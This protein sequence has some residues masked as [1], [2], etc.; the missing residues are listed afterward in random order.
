MKQKYKL[1]TGKY[2]SQRERFTWHL[3]LL[4]ILLIVVVLGSG[5]FL[6]DFYHKK[7]NPQTPTTKTTIKKITFEDK[8]FSTA[9]FSFKDSEAWNFID[10]QSTANKFVFQK[11]LPK[12]TLV[13]H[14]L[15]V[16][17]NTTPPP[18]DLAASR[19]LPI[20]INDDGKTFKVSQVSD[21]CGT[22]YKPGEIHRVS[23]RQISGATLLCDPDQGQFRVVFS[24]I[25][26]DYN[27]KLKRDNGTTANY[28]IIY[29]NQKI[30]PNSD[31]LMQVGDSF[32]AI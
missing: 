32:K 3:K 30:D 26:G 6:Y 23:T 17:I 8:N 28:I 1:G 16:Y 27:L 7:Q 21:H 4:L 29:Q 18:L 19:V 31:T 13:Q 25:G 15:I 11:Y 20:E 22:S 14:Q 2:I 10:S 12:S 9:Y 24:Q 5:V